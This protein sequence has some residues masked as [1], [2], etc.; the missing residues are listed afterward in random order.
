M[1]CRPLWT[2]LSVATLQASLPAIG[3]AERAEHWLQRSLSFY[4]R[5]P[6]AFDY[7]L[8]I[9]VEQEGQAMMKGLGE[10]TYGDA[11]HLRVVMRVNVERGGQGSAEASLLVVGDGDVVWVEAEGPS[12]ERLRGQESFADLERGAGLDLDAFGPV[13][14]LGTL[15]GLAGGP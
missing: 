13:D 6:F 14:P 8:E 5:A 9:E 10:I 1:T 4:D 7:R 2:L 15:R 12:G 11:T 3:W